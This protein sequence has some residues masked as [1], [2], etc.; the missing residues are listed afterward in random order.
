MAAALGLGP[1]RLV[2]RAVLR[3]WADKI[4]VTRWQRP[5]TLGVAAGLLAAPALA[6]A[7]FGGSS[8]VTATTLGLAVLLLLQDLAWRWL[9]LEWSVPFAALGLVAAFLDH[10]F[11]NALIGAAIGAGLLWVLQTGF[12]SLRGVEGLGTGDI[13]LAAGVGAFVGPDTIAWVLGLAALSGLAFEAVRR[14]VPKP[15]SHNRWG[16]AYGAHILW[17]FLIV[18]PL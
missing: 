9:P 5:V 16:V 12:R 6:G 10:N 11:A 18:T 1:L 15:C 8:A 3:R 14:K 4:A 17:V 13:W 7:L 2:V